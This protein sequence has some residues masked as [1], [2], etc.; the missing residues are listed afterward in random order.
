M[1]RQGT[2]YQWQLTDVPIILALA[3]IVV[4]SSLS[5][6]DDPFSGGGGADP[7]GGGQDPF[8]D[9][10]VDETERERGLRI[11]EK[12]KRERAIF[13]R[14][15]GAI[16]HATRM[17]Q[18]RDD[19]WC[20]EGSLALLHDG[21]HHNGVESFDGLLERLEYLANHSWRL[22][23]NETPKALLDRVQRE[24][25]SD[26]HDIVRAYRWC[27]TDFR[28]IS[29]SPWPLEWRADKELWLGVANTMI[30]SQGLEDPSAIWRE[31][32]KDDPKHQRLYRYCYVA[33]VRSKQPEKIDFGLIKPMLEMRQTSALVDL[34]WQARVLHTY[35]V[36]WVP[37]DHPE[38]VAVREL[39][40]TNLKSF[41]SD[42]VTSRDNDVNLRAVGR[43]YDVADWQFERP[44]ILNAVSASGV[45][46]LKSFSRVAAV[47]DSELREH[48]LTRT[49][50]LD[51]K[52]TPLRDAIKILEAATLLTL[53]IDDTIR[54]DAAPVSLKKTGTWLDCAEALLAK[55]EYRFEPLGNNIF[56]IGKPDAAR[57]TREALVRSHGESALAN[58]KLGAALRERTDLNFTETPLQDAVDFLEDLHGVQIQLFGDSRDKPVS[59]YIR[60]IPLHLGLELLC[61]DLKLNWSTL[62]E[63]VVIAPDKE[64]KRLEAG[65]KERFRRQSG[66]RREN[67]KVVEALREN[68]NIE[69][70]DTPL[71]DIADYLEDLHGVPFQ[72]F[73]D[74]ALQPFSRV[75]RG[76]PL[77]LGMDLI[78]VDLQVT[79]DTFDEFVI[80][81]S[82][83][84]MKEFHA[85][86]RER[87]RRLANLRR[88]GGKIA[89]SLQA[90]TKIEFIETPLS[91]VVEYLSKSHGGIPFRFTD[92]KIGHR[93]ITI[94]LSD[95]QLDLALDFTTFKQDLAWYT[96]GKEVVIG[97]KKE[98]REKTLMD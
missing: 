73:G 24:F 64:M 41:K 91:G 66:V 84:D 95:I 63:L 94:Y 27:A 28:D 46:A 50:T 98:I 3:M 70:I 59:R 62:D 10:D 47:L 71:E 87:L 69:F 7:F 44:Q 67:P 58:E 88:D 15:I 32:M 76:V 65:R 92:P 96:N 86:R 93:P 51:C 97:S 68:T 83:E 38:R 80:I 53:V 29:D 1:K 52:D 54:V 22:L 12:Q 55:T 2:R 30:R 82:A 19:A 40:L 57:L 89:E 25:E 37:V 33:L 81:A 8:A 48:L 60:G 31:K 11:I 21:W 4:V 26:K 75:V 36:A 34:A 72:V 45:E 6:A 74:V 77:D 18:E 17:A 79:W 13:E 43:M 23:P 78:C 49:T 5:S 90:K 85:L 39:F 35:A 16:D 61:A 56:W 20:L 42:M 9:P 14:H